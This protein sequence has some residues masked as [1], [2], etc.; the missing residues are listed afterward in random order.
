MVDAVVPAKL[1]PVCI[2]VVGISANI[3][4]QFSVVRIAERSFQRTRSAGE[5]PEGFHRIALL[6]SR[7]IYQLQD[8]F[9][10]P[11]ICRDS[12]NICSPVMKKIFSE[13]RNSFVIFLSCDFS[14]CFCH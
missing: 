7:I 9:A 11:R 12:F 4:I 14:F 2:F 10:P 13:I 3:S 5:H 6:A 8:Q 1:P